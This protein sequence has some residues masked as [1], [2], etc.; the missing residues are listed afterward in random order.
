M[1]I[2]K[3]CEVCSQARIRFAEYVTNEDRT[4]RKLPWPK[5][6]EPR[7]QGEKSICLQALWAHKRYSSNPT[8]GVK[9]TDL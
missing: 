3:E 7:E 6:K 1:R 2:S 4:M 8:E 5:I 9:N